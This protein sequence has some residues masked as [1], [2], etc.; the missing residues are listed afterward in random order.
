MPISIQEGLASGGRLLIPFSGIGGFVGL[1]GEQMAS[2]R[3]EVDLAF[4]PGSTQVSLFRLSLTSAGAG[5]GEHGASTGHFGA[6]GIAGLGILEPQPG[7]TWAL[8]LEY[9]G[10]QAYEELTRRIGRTYVPPDRFMAPM[11][12]LA[13]TLDGTLR[14]TGDGTER[15]LAFSGSFRFDSLPG[16]Q[17]GWVRSLRTTLADNPVW[18]LFQSDY[19]PWAERRRRLKIRPVRL[20]DR[21]GDPAPTGTDARRQIE[22]AQRIWGKCCIDLEVLEPVDRIEPDLKTSEEPELVMDSFKDSSENTVEVFFVDHPLPSY[23]GGATG[24]CGWN[25]ASVVLTEHTDHNPNLLAHE[26]GHVFAGV[27]PNPPTSSNFFWSGEG[28]TVLKATLH[29]NEANP[30]RN[31]LSNC[32]YAHNPA[33]T[34]PS[35]QP[36][37]LRPDE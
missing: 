28:G 22:A 21:C 36:C 18:P 15:N 17:L 24:S 1:A 2:V 5:I 37:R 19:A 11:E 25:T 31:T 8:H 29:N 27:H 4:T 14:E 20:L 9:L 7:G 35:P 23:G 3:G 16:G 26:L 6:H 10:V 13:G 30:D 33:L 12:S 32:L 34:T